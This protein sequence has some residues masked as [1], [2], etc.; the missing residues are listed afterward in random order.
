MPTKIQLILESQVPTQVSTESSLERQI[1]SASEGI[2]GWSRHWFLC[3]LIK[4]IWESSQAVEWAGME[5]LRTIPGTLSASWAM[6][7][8]CQTQWKDHP[9][10]LYNLIQVPGNAFGTPQFTCEDKSSLSK[11]WKWPVQDREWRLCYSLHLKRMQKSDVCSLSHSAMPRSQPHLWNWHLTTEASS[12]QS[13][14]SPSLLAGCKPDFLT[15]S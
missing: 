7:G 6:Q 4:C 5:W 15:G 8:R 3:K 2:W 14:S 9:D 13:D 10:T 12:F 1:C 11:L